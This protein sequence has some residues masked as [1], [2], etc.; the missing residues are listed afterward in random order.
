[1][2]TG[3]DVNN[4]ELLGHTVIGKTAYQV[5]A[6]AMS[7]SSIAAGVHGR[8]ALIGPNGASYFVTDYG[9]DFRINSV[10][11]GGSKTQHWAPSPRPLRGLTRAHLSLFINRH[12]V[13]A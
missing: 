2:T 5:F 12:E 1:M 6:L 8:Y 11:C 10:A 4:N 13:H 3:I 7:E 9:P